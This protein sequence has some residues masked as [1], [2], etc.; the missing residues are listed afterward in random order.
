[1]VGITILMQCHSPGSSFPANGSLLLN[2]ANPASNNCSLQFFTARNGSVLLVKKVHAFLAKAKQSLNSFD[3]S[4][5]VSALMMPLSSLVWKRRTRCWRARSLDSKS[6]YDNIID[7]VKDVM[8]D[9]VSEPFECSRQFMPL[10]LPP[11][12]E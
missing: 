5:S 4:L 12:P 3:M 8:V 7:K 9:L 10:P 11:L 6:L 2:F 1:M